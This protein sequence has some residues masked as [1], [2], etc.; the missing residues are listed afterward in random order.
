MKHLTILLLISFHASAFS[1][2]RGY[3]IFMINIGSESIFAAPAYRLGVDGIERSK[4]ASQCWNAGPTSG[5]GLAMTTRIRVP[6]GITKELGEQLF[7]G[8]QNSIKKSQ[9]IM[10][11]NS[12][13]G[14]YVVNLHNNK[15]TILG[16]GANNPTTKRISN[17]VLSE[18]DQTKAA[19]DFDYALCLASKPFKKGF[20]P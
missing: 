5:Q 12:Q 20:G 17:V 19:Q 7:S 18:T 2:I 6:P 4:R 10:K 11:Q 3:Y 8:D 15:V 13:D 14:L 1:G 16:V 9:F